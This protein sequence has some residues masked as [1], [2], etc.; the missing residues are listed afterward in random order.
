MAT[1][2]MEIEGRIMQEADKRIGQLYLYD[3]I[4]P[5]S[6][7]WWSGE[8]I[9]SE[10]SEKAIRDKL[11]EMGAVDELEVHI[12][13]NG[14]YVTTGLCV[15][16]QIKD[17]ACPKKTAYIDGIAASIAS[18]IAM[19]CDEVV[20]RNASLMMIHD[21][22]ANA[23]GNA[24]ELRKAADDLDI[25]TG[26]SKTAYLE[27]ANGKIDE[28]KLSDLMAKESW[29]TAAQCY[30]YGLCDRIAESKKADAEFPKQYAS[31]VAA[32][33]QNAESHSAEKEQ[34]RQLEAKLKELEQRISEPQAPKAEK[35]EVLSEPPA[36]EGR[37]KMLAA[38]LAGM[39]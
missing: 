21:A 34:I 13:S 37:A 16:S 7:D 10:T 28:G 31:A 25:I 18:V 15:Y 4:L 11:A 3:E 32:M 17:F 23:K 35:E 8:V 26:A 20:M 39:I 9:R 12:S 19:S 14:G 36:K 22:W 30:E 24:R 2:I 33:M 29:L 6:Y 27:H 5:D 1:P 38:M